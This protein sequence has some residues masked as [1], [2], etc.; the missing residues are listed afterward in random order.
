MLW[1][2]PADYKKPAGIKIPSEDIVEYVRTNKLVK[3]DSE[4]DFLVEEVVVESSRVNRKAYIESFRED[5]G[6]AN[7]MKKVAM[8]G[9]MSL[10]NQRHRDLLPV[11]ETGKEIVQD[12]RVLQEGEEAIG[13]LGDRMRKV[14]AAMPK[15]LTKGMSLEDFLTKT[16]QADIDA[17]VAALKTT[18]EGG[19]E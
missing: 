13:A 3:A 10:F 18:A 7:I 6:I 11:D 19:A 17:F 1:T 15:E 16:S 5:V 12:I 2:R 14:F 9:D 8:T 4:T